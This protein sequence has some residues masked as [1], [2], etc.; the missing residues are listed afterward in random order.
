MEHMRRH[1][2]MGVVLG[3]AVVFFAGMIYAGTK[4][5]DVVKMDTA[6]YE[7]HTKGIVEFS[8]KKHIDDYKA[9]CGE[10]HHD[11]D[12]KPRADLKDGDN[13]EK[14]IDC[15]K[16]PGEKPKGKDAPKLSKK[17]E[18]EYHAEALHE[19]CRECH[20]KFNKEKNTKTAPTT[21]TQCHPK[22]S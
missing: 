17:E 5:P 3:L 22:T 2:I 13:V 19:N 9:T 18:L 10:C 14:C 11:K 7:K 6:G 8:H 15:H 4:V 21:C 16:K 12:G 1:L 20:K